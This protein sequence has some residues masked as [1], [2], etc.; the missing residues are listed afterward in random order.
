LKRDG[1]SG[2]GTTLWTVRFAV[3]ARCAAAFQEA[4]EIDAL[5]TAAFELPGGPLW[6]V[7]GLYA[8]PPEAVRLAETL[9]VPADAFGLPWPAVAIEAVPERDWVSHSQKLLAPVSAG[10]FHVHGS[11]DRGTAP[12]GAWAVEIEAGRAFGTGRHETTRGCLLAL[13]R[14]PR[15]RLP[16]RPLDLGTG[17]GVLAIAM[18]RLWRQRVLATDIDPVAVATAR[19]N[20]RL[21]GLAPWV[22][23]ARSDGPSGI[24]RRDGPW[25]PI[26]ANILAGP[27]IEMACDIALL[28]AP[29]GRLVLA[30]LLARQEAEVLSAYRRVGLHLHRRLRL[31]DWPTLVLRRGG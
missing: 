27:L 18:A 31:G 21:N 4:L 8:A 2:S 10:R 24:V 25:D 23:T 30:G 16:P 9:A 7:E 28:L 5:S 13:Q 15:G 22:R 29:G 20:V 6:Q 1:A 3:P 26:V 17:S 14:L 11:H 12:G 19:A